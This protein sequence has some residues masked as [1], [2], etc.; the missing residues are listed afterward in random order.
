MSDDEG[1]TP[2]EAVAH[3]APELVTPRLGKGTLGTWRSPATS[4]LRA[5]MRLAAKLGLTGRQTVHEGRM[6]VGA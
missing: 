4:G 6:R 5:G 1:V 2:D 3:I